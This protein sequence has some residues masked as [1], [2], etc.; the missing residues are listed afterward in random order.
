[1]LHLLC[2]HLY[3]FKLKKNLPKEEN[4]SFQGF[5]EVGTREKWAWNSQGSSNEGFLGNGCSLGSTIPT[6]MITDHDIV[7]EFD[8]KLTS[9]KAR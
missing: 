9:G 1:M 6:S 5:K 3:I 2:F 7:I 4:N 8:R